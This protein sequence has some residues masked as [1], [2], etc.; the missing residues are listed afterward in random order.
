MLKFSRIRQITFSL[1]LLLLSHLFHFILLINLSFH[2]KISQNQ[3][4]HFFTF[5]SSPFFTLLFSAISVFMLKPSKPGKTNKAKTIKRFYIFYFFF[6]LEDANSGNDYQGYY[7]S[8]TGLGWVGER[9]VWRVG[10]VDARGGG[11]RGEGVFVGWSG[12]GW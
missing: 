4:N 2:A 10:W 12:M 3:T 5:S 9:K 6:P 7:V 11:G 8:S 1:F